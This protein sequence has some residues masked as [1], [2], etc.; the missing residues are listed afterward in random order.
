MHVKRQRSPLLSQ[1]VCMCTNGCACARVWR[2]EL[3]ACHSSAIQNNRDIDPAHS[4]L[5]DVFLDNFWGERMDAH[6]AQHQSY[7]PLTVLTFRWNF[8]VHGLDVYGYVCF[9]WEVCCLLL[10]VLLYSGQS[11][12]SVVSCRCGA[13]SGVCLFSASPG[14]CVLNVRVQVSRNQRC[15]PR[16]CHVPVRVRGRTRTRAPNTLRS[17]GSRGNVCGAPSVR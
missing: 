13:A 14:A 9:V 6:D 2:V 17:S 10:C 16:P 1:Y 15:A 4:T 8:M 5:S 7:R 12:G 11:P 3:V